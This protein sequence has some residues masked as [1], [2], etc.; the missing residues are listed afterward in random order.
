[1]QSLNS[2][3][4][5]EQDEDDYWH[6]Q[7]VKKETYIKCYEA[8]RM[9]GASMKDPNGIA[10]SNDSSPFPTNLIQEIHLQFNANFNKKQK[11]IL[12]SYL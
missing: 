7:L 4:L 10:N 1:M 8:F 9:I 12:L 2:A 6:T 3:I 11:N 5:H